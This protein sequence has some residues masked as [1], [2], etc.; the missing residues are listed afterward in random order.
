M[1]KSFNILRELASLQSSLPL[2]NERI[3]E[4]PEGYF[5]TLS[6]TVLDNIRNFETGSQLC[7]IRREM[8]YHFPAEYFDR[9]D[10]EILQTIQAKAEIESVD[11]ELDA[12]SPFLRG[13]KKKMPYKVPRRYFHKVNMEGSAFSKAKVVSIVPQIWIRYAAAAV[14]TGILALSALLVFDSPKVDQGKAVARFEKNL[15]IEIQK[16]SDHDLSEFIKYTAVTNL[17]VKSGNELRP[18]SKDMLKDV[19]ES[20]LKEFLDETADPEVAEDVK[21][22]MN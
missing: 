19:P 13:I 18:D 22:L 11:E 17:E 6:N 9:L 15:N 10:K 16:M 2:H 4:V 7:N 1:P 14:I 5:G 20:E 21:P 3:F 12:L 8:P